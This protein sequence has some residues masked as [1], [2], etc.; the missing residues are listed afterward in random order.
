MRKKIILTCG[1]VN[2]IGPE[3]ILKAVNKLFNPDKY[4]FL[5]IIPE[6]VFLHYKKSCGI[7]LPFRKINEPDKLFPDKLNILATKKIKMRPGKSTVES[8][9]VAFESILRGVQIGRNSPDSSIIVTAPISKKSF[10]LAGIKFIGHTDFLEN[11]FRVKN[12]AMFFVSG[13]LKVTPATIHL[14]LRKIFKHLT[15]QYF[16]NF[17]PFVRSVLIKDFAIKNPEIALLGLNPHSGE[18]GRLGNEEIDLLNP[19]LSK[20]K[21]LSGPFPPDAFWGMKREKNFDLTVGLY[22]DQV[23][24]PFKMLAMNSGVN[25]TAGLPIIRTSPDHGTAFDIAGK[26]IADETSMVNSIK[27][28][29]KIAKNREK[30]G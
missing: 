4:T 12:I 3:I 19:L 24:I 25:F 16:N 14:P 11:Y 5:I 8:G 10:E 20:F 13:K 9:K 27:L 26:L 1:D 18:E 29:L 21:Y 7:N 2:G 6:N 30:Y 28:A 23:L 17:I 15:P 22:H